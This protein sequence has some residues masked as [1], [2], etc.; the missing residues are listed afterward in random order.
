MALNIENISINQSYEICVANLE[1]IV[2]SLVVLMDINTSSSHNSWDVIF[3]N[4]SVACLKASS[5]S[6]C[7]HYIVNTQDHITKDAVF[8]AHVDV[9]EFMD[10]DSFLWAQDWVVHINTLSKEKLMEFFHVVASSKHALVVPEV[11]EIIAA[12]P[13]HHILVIIIKMDLE[14]IAWRKAS[15]KL[16]FSDK[17]VSKDLELIFFFLK[18]VLKDH[19]S[20]GLV[21]GD[22]IEAHF[23]SVLCWVFI[24]EAFFLTESIDIAE[25]L[26]ARWI[27]VPH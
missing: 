15:S 20:V 18:Q 3:T 25:S 2:A 7:M 17:G 22:K 27:F 24:A 13:L 1:N 26:T 6:E 8:W 16:L 23:I 9:S 12:D 11:V 21:F 10:V 4:E 5:S 14:T 19:C